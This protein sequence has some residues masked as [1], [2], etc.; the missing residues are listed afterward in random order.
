MKHIIADVE[1]RKEISAASQ[2]FLKTLNRFFK[3]SMKLDL[4]KSNSTLRKIPFLK[5]QK[6][7]F[8]LDRRE[9]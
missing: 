7:F 4:F 6:R 9:F 2:N 1:K 8:S 5:K 3:S